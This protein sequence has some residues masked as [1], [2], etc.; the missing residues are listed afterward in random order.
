M[1]RDEGLEDEDEPSYR[2]PLP[3]D[4]R[5]W[6]HPSEMA[7][8]AEE[9]APRPPRVWAIAAV[10]GLVGAVVSAGLTVALTRDDDP[11]LVTR[12]VEREAVPLRPI[13]ADG[14]Q[15]VSELAARVRP[16]VVQLV[17]D[18]REGSGVVFRDDGHILTNH[19]VTKG[20]TAVAVVL[21]DGRRLTGTVVGTDDATDLAVVKVEGGPFPPAVMG[22]A[23]TLRTGDGVVTVGG[24]AVSAGIVSALGR[25]TDAG[26]TRLYDMIQTDASVA[27]ASSGGALLDR[28]GAVIGIS[29][30]IGAADGVGFA[31]PIDIAWSVASELIDHG[32][33]THV[34]LGVEGSDHAD[35][36]A[37]VTKV[38]TGS[39]AHHAGLQVGDRIVSVAGDP[40]R[41]M[42]AVVVALRSRRV[43]EQVG[44]RYVRDG[45][46]RDLRVTLRERPRRE[47]V[48]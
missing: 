35:G 24:P 14:P 19:H 9:P 8:V 23:T 25:T 4:D 29:T 6:R 42:A 32:R 2:P 27:A 20:M 48:D 18:S 12:V 45:A 7:P 47:A 44:L 13:E 37:T 43:G 46:T 41:T 28:S 36:G 17:S 10:A 5:L 38:M 40:V 30:A 39:P 15:S 34:W 22:T 1:P 3:P 16:A 26:G 33:A 31:T 21:P 11:A